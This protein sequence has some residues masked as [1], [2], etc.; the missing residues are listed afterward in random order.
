MKKKLH[1]SFGIYHDECNYI[2]ISI[3]TWIFTICTWIFFI[4]SSYDIIKSERQDYDDYIEFLINK[5]EQFHDVEMKITVVPEA[6]LVVLMTAVVLHWL[7]DEQLVVFV[8]VPTEGVRPGV[9]GLPRS[10][11]LT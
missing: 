5:K 3:S 2:S 7:V 10:K 4:L 9:L 6:V 1:D 11:N 8:A